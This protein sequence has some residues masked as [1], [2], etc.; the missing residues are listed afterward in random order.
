MKVNQVEREMQSMKQVG[1]DPPEARVFRSSAISESVGA[2][3]AMLVF[4]H[5]TKHAK[6]TVGVPLILVAQILA[7]IAFYKYL[8]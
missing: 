1:T 8:S 2:F 4:R 6:F 7:V 3:L 5:K